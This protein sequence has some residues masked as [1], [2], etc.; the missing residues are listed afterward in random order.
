VE[1]PQVEEIA[2]NNFDHIEQR[3]RS[4]VVVVEND[5]TPEP[6]PKPNPHSQ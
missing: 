4:D 2:E 3:E 1:E 6:A 5:T